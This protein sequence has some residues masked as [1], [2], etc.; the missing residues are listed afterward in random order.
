MCPLI[1]TICIKNGEV[2]RVDYHMR[3]MNRAR[4]DLFGCEDTI[5]PLTVLNNVQVAGDVLLKCRIIYGKDIQKMGI[6]PY[7]KKQIN[8]LRLIVDDE[9][10]YSYKYE[11]RSG[12]SSLLALMGDADDILIVKNGKITDTS[13]ANVVF[14]DGVKWITP[15]TPLLAGT[16]REFL[17]E[18]GVIT[19]ADISPMDL[20]KFKY[21]CLINAMLDLEDLVVDVKNIRK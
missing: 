14:F 18:Q 12:L 17:L 1:E 7:K 4:K 6:T 19:E 16:R 13:F 20:E 21:V 15:S 9:I 3:R 10:E 2:Q 11:D 5:D 8:S